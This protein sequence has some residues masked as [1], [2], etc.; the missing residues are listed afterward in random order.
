MSLTPLLMT[1]IAKREITTPFA[2]T[3][4]HFDLVSSFNTLKMVIHDE[5]NRF[6]GLV[7][8]RDRSTNLLFGSLRGDAHQC[9]PGL[10]RAVEKRRSSLDENGGNCHPVAVAV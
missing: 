1:A 8:R 10:A 2:T 9:F 7:V 4:P 3:E 5:F 6:T